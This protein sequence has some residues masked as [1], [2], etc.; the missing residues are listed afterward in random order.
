MNAVLTLLLCAVVPSITADDDVD[1]AEA[2]W[3]TY[4]V[5]S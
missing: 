1:Q 5:T 3:A 2:K 4:K